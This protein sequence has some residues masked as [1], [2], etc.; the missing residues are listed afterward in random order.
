MARVSFS[1]YSMWSNCP[2]QY[3][4][5]YIDGLSTSKS[6][7]HSVFGSA[8]H[9]TLQ[10]YLSRCLRISKSQADKGM[11]TKAFL[12]EKMREFFIKESNDGKDPICSK[13]ELVEFLED[14][15]LILDYF[16]KSKNFNNFF[17]LKDDELVAIEQVI[18]TK[19]AEHVNFLGF[20]DFIVRSKSTGRYRITDFKT[21]TKGWSKYQKSDPVK[22]TQILLYK[23]FYAEL[24]SI[25]PDIIDVE[26]MILKRKVSE[27]AD[28]HIPRI[29]RH[30]P[31]SGKPSMNK[32]WKGFTDFVDTVFNEDGSYRTD[33]EFFKKP[34]KLCSWCEFFGTHCDG[35]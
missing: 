6:N 16:Q 25:S 33:I 15:Y 26:F 14:G 31:A 7:I 22:N 13:E 24:L 9:E 23:K 21:S 29:S 11:D 20:I 18:N 5:S 12:K 1:Q 30:V 35:K 10:E 17:S 8:M 2:Q 4:L 32:A 3:K 34:S 19:I 27:N 28:Y